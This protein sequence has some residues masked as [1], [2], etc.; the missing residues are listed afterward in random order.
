MVTTTGRMRPS[1]PPVWALKPLQNSMMLTPCWP[2]AGPTGGE[3]F[4]L[5]AGICSFTIARTFFIEQPP[6]PRT[7]ARPQPSQALHLVVLELDRG[8][9]PED[10]DDDLHPAALGVHV[11]DDPLEVHERP[12]D[13]AN[14]VAALEDRLR[15]WL[16]RAGFHLPENVVHLIL[17][18]RDR[19]VPGPDEAGHLGRRPHQV[20]RLVGE[21]HLDEHVPG[22]ELL[23][24]LA[25]LLVADLDHLLGR[26]QD[27][28]DLFRHAEN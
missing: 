20:P 5:P 9:P 23:L 14:L 3:G 26:H 1:C 8:R 25:L 11:I 21:L 2:S 12:V 10:R 27:T 24:G 15:L 22:K 7:R 13:H 16:L 18:E 19:L 4:A 6:S 17:R 28:G